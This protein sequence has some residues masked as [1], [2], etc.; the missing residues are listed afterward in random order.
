MP[1]GTLLKGAQG[2]SPLDRIVAEDMRDG[3]RGPIQAIRFL[4][5]ALYASLWQRPEPLAGLNEM[6]VEQVARLH[7]NIPAGVIAR[8]RASPFYPIQYLI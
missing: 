1:D 7:E 4:E 3:L 5:R 6:S 2:N 8:H